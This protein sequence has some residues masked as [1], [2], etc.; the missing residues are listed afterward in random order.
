MPGMGEGMGPPSRALQQRRFTPFSP[1]SAHV[2]GLSGTALILAE[3]VPRYSVMLEL[4][5]TGADNTKILYGPDR[6]LS[7]DGNIPPFTK[8]C[9]LVA[10]QLAEPGA[11]GEAGGTHEGPLKHIDHL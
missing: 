5:D 3:V 1:A 9:P 4:F 8:T 10:G 11:A 6:G 2:W 7:S